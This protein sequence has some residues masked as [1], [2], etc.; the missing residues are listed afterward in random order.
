MLESIWR[1]SSFNT[2]PLS[3]N[4][5]AFRM[6]TDFEITVSGCDCLVAALSTCTGLVHVSLGCELE[7]PSML[8]CALGRLSALTALF[9]QS[10]C[11]VF[12]EAEV[13]D[14][15][16]ASISV[17]GSLKSVHLASNF[18]IPRLKQLCTALCHHQ[19]LSTITLEHE[20]AGSAAEK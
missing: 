6:S 18:S 16:C 5:T 17:L 7:T 1:S 3:P 4:L 19:A 20:A 2:L 9:L 12:E 10:S 15:L 13:V 14:A 11:S 8:C